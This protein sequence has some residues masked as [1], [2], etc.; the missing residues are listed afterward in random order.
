MHPNQSLM[1]YILGWANSEH[2]NWALVGA[3]VIIAQVL[4]IHPTR[5][6]FPAL[7]RLGHPM[8]P[9]PPS[10]G[11]R[12]S[13]PALTPSRPAHLQ[14]LALW[15]PRA[16]SLCRPV[17]AQGPLSQ[18]FQPVSSWLTSGFAI[19]ARSTLLPG[20]GAG[21]TLMSA[22]TI[23]ATGLAFLL[24]HPPGQ[25]SQLPQVAHTQKRRTDA[26]FDNGIRI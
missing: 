16:S 9:M 22:T 24:S 17:N 15:V 20:Q 2:W 3:E 1:I 8:P 4:L 7:L 12:G 14:T 23:K 21:P 26:L 10:P 18:M 19:R 13:P 11:G 25:L 6:S 5:M